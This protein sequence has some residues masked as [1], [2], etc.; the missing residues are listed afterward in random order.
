[1]EKKLPPEWHDAFFELVAYP[2]NESE[3]INEKILDPAMAG[4]ADEEI[5][6]LTAIYNEQIAGGKW[7]NMMSDNP[8]KQMEFKPAQK[9][10]AAAEPDSPPDP[11]AADFPG[12]DFAEVGNRCVMQAE[13]ASSFIPGKDANWQKI[14]GLGYNGEAVFIFPAT[15]PVRATPDRILAE[16]PCLQ[17][18]LWLRETNDWQVTVRSLPTFSVETGKPQR[19]AIAF[20]DAPPQIISLPASM[21]ERDRQWQENVLRNAA[22]TGS[23]HTLAATGLHTLKI[24]MVDPGIVIDTISVEGQG[25]APLGYVWPKENRITGSH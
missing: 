5:H 10:P 16:S 1:L 14:T 3:L 6:R 18:K 11:E 9:T 23:K 2:V 20:D 13:H 12:A 21:S 25:A 8:R 17:F 24:W 22:L 7:R 4:T 15:V 19:Y